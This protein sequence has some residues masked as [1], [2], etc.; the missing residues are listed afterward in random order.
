[1][2]NF[3]PCWSIT[4][5]VDKRRGFRDTNGREKEGFTS[6]IVGIPYRGVEPP[7][8]RKSF[9]PGRELPLLIHAKTGISLSPS[10]C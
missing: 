8:P 9:H 7:P 1:M 5:V 4:G 3:D 10:A 2:E 6:G